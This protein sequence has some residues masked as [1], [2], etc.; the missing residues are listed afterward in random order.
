MLT[1][2]KAGQSIYRKSLY[3]LWA[4]SSTLN[5]FQSKKLK[6]KKRNTFL[7]WTPCPSLKFLI[8][9][10]RTIFTSRCGTP[11]TQTH[12][13]TH[14]HRC[15]HVR[16]HTCAHAHVHTCSTVSCTGT[17][18]PTCCTHL[19]LMQLW[20]WPTPRHQQELWK[21]TV[22]GAF[23]LHCNCVHSPTLWL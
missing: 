23:G 18:A 10:S 15:T 11:N 22:T 12:T 20:L 6:K 13:R 5:L 9:L 17:S 4:F 1:L 16:T 3:Y 19:Q 8:S 2:E 7:L 14:I 21:E